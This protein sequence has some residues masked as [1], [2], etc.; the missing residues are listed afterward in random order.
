MAPLSVICSDAFD[1]SSS[2]VRIFLAGCLLFGQTSSGKPDT[3]DPCGNGRGHLDQRASALWR[4]PDG[5]RLPA[6]EDSVLTRIVRDVESQ[7]LLD[8][9][10]DGPNYAAADD[11]RRRVSRSTPV[12]RFRLLLRIWIIDFRER[13]LFDSSVFRVSAAVAGTTAGLVLLL[14]RRGDSALRLLSGVHRSG[15]LSWADD[16]IEWIF[17]NALRGS[18]LGRPLTTAIAR[19]VQNWTDAPPTL[20]EDPERLLGPLAMVLRSPDARHKGV[21]LL[22]YNYVFPLFAKC[23]DVH[24]IGKK[25]HIVLEPSWSGYCNT[26]VLC[27]ARVAPPVFVQAYEPRDA[28]IVRSLDAGFDVVPTSANW[29]VDHR[30][31]TPMS[32][33]QKDADLI[34]VA[35]WGGYKRHLA[36][37]RGLRRLRGLH[38][39]LRVLLVGYNL[40]MTKDEILGFAD[41]FDVADCLEVFENLTQPEVNR[42]LNRARVNVLWSRREGV[43]R[44]IIEG[45]FANLPC[46]VREGFNYGYRYEYINPSTGAFA[47]ERD[48]AEVALRLLESADTLRPREWTMQHM[49]C[50]RSTA[51]LRATV[52]GSVDTGEDL[53][54][55][56]NGLHGMHYWNE[57]DA[58]RFTADYEFLRRMRI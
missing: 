8:D 41:H 40:G 12:E 1:T 31:F 50:Q 25:Y 27:Y 19:Q 14:A 39:R 56:V 22:Q 29:W 21:L 51:I 20:A 4:G 11:S 23:F 28:H 48:F 15:L 37:F 32:D 58:G 16:L 5:R 54:V 17:R 36:F 26:E 44:A 24:A 35:G 7:V 47:S 30:V 33:V 34:M 13:V 45:M 6:P 2:N 49:S 53:A 46:I 38:P 18:R 52:D 43:N 9:R 57:A 42:L 10:A 55:K 3:D